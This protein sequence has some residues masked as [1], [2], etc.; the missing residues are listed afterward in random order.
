MKKFIF[1]VFVFVSQLV[2]AQSLPEE[3]EVVMDELSYLSNAQKFEKIESAFTSKPNDPWKYW[4]KAEVYAELN[5]DKNTRLNYEKSI[6]LDANFSAGYG[7]YS[8][9]LMDKDTMNFKRVIELSSKAIELAPRE[10]IYRIVRA[11]AYY[12][13]K[14][15]EKAYADAEVFNKYLG[16]ELFD[17]ELMMLRCLYALGRQEELTNRMATLD[18][19]QIFVEPKDALFLASVY[20]AQGSQEKACA[21]Y[22]LAADAYDLFSEEVPAK[23]LEQIKKCE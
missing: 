11:Q 21:C 1:L 18:V 7:S 10:I 15:Y 3:Y 20:S 22:R 4:M 2:S 9:Y 6:Q 14:N 8:R 13:D 5:D 17:G 16:D 19:S 12:Y 23:V